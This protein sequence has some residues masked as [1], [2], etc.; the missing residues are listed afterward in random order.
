MSPL[1]FLQERICS[2]GIMSG[3][4][5]KPKEGHKRKRKPT[6]HRPGSQPQDRRPARAAQVKGRWRGR[7][8]WGEVG[9]KGIQVTCERAQ[10]AGN[11]IGAGTMPAAPLTAPALSLRPKKPSHPSASVGGLKVF[12]SA[13][14]YMH[15]ASCVY[16]GT[17]YRVVPLNQSKKAESSHPSTNP[18]FRASLLFMCCLNARA[19]QGQEG[20]FSTHASM[21]P[22]AA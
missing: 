2:K 13:S 10:R 17:L 11:H 15:F 22:R 5:D 1:G 14:L 21:G 8:D 7:C 9:S 4:W 18:P 6:L 12:P 20:S 16:E 3:L 19:C